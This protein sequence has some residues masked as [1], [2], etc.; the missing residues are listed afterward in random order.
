MAGTTGEAVIPVDV[1]AS[2]VQAVVA[3]ADILMLVVR[4]DVLLLVVPVDI[5]VVVV[6]VVDTL[7]VDA[8]VAVDMV[9]ADM[10]VAV[11]TS[12]SNPM[13]RRTTTSCVSSP[14]RQI[15]RCCH[16]DLWRFSAGV[17]MRELRRQAC[18]HSSL[19]SFWDTCCSRSQPLILA[20]MNDA[21][22]LA[23]AA[24]LILGAILVRL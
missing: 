1:R 24:L 20:N 5:L 6:P 22:R 11:G 3:P 16:V 7:V 14:F 19:H 12:N 13:R 15:S 18:L 4:A 23:G 17:P 21:W 9:A 8:P 10:V 2:D